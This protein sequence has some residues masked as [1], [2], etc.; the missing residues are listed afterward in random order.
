MANNTIKGAGDVYEPDLYKN[1]EQSAKSVLPL[2]ESINKILQS[3]AASSEKLIKVQ[4]KDVESLK[5]VNKGVDEANVAFKEKLELDKRILNAQKQLQRERLSELKLQKDRE[6]AFDRADKQE[7]IAIK[8]AQKLR[9]QAIDNANAYKVLTKQVNNAQARFKRLAAQYGVNSKEAVRANIKFAQLDDRLRRINKTAR[10]GRRDVGRYGLAFR[11]V[12]ISLKS[13]FLAG[14]VVGIIRGVGAAFTD[15]FE[16]LRSFDKELQ[17]IAGVSGIARKDLGQLE[18]D[19]ISVS[20]SSIKTSNEVA[21]LASTLFTLGNSE[22]SVRLL[23]KPVNDLSI[24]L[25]TTSDEAADFLG[26]TLNAFGKG[27]ESG[28]EFADIIA[29]VRTS[30]SLD[31]QRIK[32]ALGWDKFQHK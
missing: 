9:K 16:R 28:Q 30:T 10:D 25:N 18:K 5:Q 6:K 1:L 14:G 2:L 7:K 26:Q 13:L 27:A 8:S 22:R 11:E 31:F 3:T 12:G 15:A 17:N 21:K 29:N 23:L 4:V 32:D 24:A 20:G 19:I